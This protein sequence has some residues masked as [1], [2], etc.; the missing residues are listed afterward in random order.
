M[1]AAV[2]AQGIT[3]APGQPAAAAPG[4]PA[5]AAPGR[6]SVAASAQP[7]PPVLELDAVTKTYPGHP[8]V[9]ALRGVSFTV[10]PGELVAI[11]GP[12]GSGKTTLLQLMGTLARPTTGTV[13]VTGLDVA[14]LPDRRLSA[15][16]ATRVGFV[17][18]QFFLTEHAT[19]LDNVA[20]GLLYGGAPLPERRSRA[21]EALARVGLAHKLA[22]RPTALSG[23]ERQ[24]V[25]IA[26]ALAGRP[27]I[28][29]AD[30]PT[31][32]LDS[33]TGRTILGLLTE[34][35]ATGTTIVV[36]THDQDIARR[37]PRRIRILDGRIIADEA[38]P[39]R[40]EGP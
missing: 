12:S 35:N 23:G 33:A 4:H 16:R 8:P 25:A 37:L 24:R 1:S 32:N 15:L 29:L 36:I 39:A 10:A 13:R 27:A 14:A 26:R 20:N 2:P 5:V 19:V 34:L 6:A 40:L 7:G 18:Q 9:A 30:E 31:G 17:F 3:P 21:A 28:V 11:T 22:V 38:Q